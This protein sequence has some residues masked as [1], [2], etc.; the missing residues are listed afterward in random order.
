MNAAPLLIIGNKNY[1]SWSLRAWIAMRKAGVAF[2]EKRLLLNTP[3]FY[4][5]IGRLSP[6]GLVPVLR[7]DDILVWDSLAIAEYVNETWAGG[8]LWPADREKRARARAISAEMHAGFSL[9]RSQ[10]PMN[11]RAGERRVPVDA[12]LQAEIDRIAGI[13]EDCL[14]TSGGPWLFGAFSLAD[15]M[16]LPV[17]FRFACYGVRPESRGRAYMENALADADVMDW[18]RAAAAE[19]E[20]VSADEAGA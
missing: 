1:S 13:W 8:S 4:E 6:S 3:A 16:Y 20:V 17:V 11:C 10:M 18:R 9:L 15:A 19:S 5:E 2:E 7:H 12:A 14:E